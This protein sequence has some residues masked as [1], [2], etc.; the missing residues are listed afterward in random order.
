[1]NNRIRGTSLFLVLAAALCGCASVDPQP[2]DQ[3]AAGLKSLREG[4]AAQ[5][6]IDVRDARNRFVQRA[7]SGAIDVPDLQLAWSLPFG[8]KYGFG[9]EPL[10][11][12]LDRF[13][14]NLEAL[15]NAMVTYANL[16]AKLAGKEDVNQTRFDQLTKDLNANASAAVEALDLEIST[17]DTALLSTAAVAIFR[18]VIEKQR[19]KDLARA[20]RE[21]QPRVDEYSK[22]VQL[23][24]K[25]FATGVTVDYDDQT[26][27]IIND[28]A[29]RA[30][31]PR[32]G[33]R[34]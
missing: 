33:A 3:F 31:D 24:I 23:A 11:V 2:F 16:L 22:Q 1:M 34:C 28:A 19:G 8:Y 18:A 12:K 4:T 15:H 9:D 17:G 14:R 21:V 6:V 13:Q 32:L 29:T 26:N 30:A 27:P 5:A 10:Y 7:E 25:F 20:I